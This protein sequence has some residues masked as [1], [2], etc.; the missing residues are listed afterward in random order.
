MHQIQVL[1]SFSYFFF[2][3]LFIFSQVL[4]NVTLNIVANINLQE[5]MLMY[6]AGTYVLIDGFIEYAST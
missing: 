2:A 1:P 4:G 3:P 6:H 5:L